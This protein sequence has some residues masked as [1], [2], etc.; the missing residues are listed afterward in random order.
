MTYL[1]L[2]RRLDDEHRREENKANTTKRPMERRIYP[3]GNDPKGRPYESLRW[4]RFKDMAPSEMFVIV[5]GTRVAEANL[6]GRARRR[7][8]ACRRGTS[9]PMATTPCAA[10]RRSAFCH[11][12]LLV[13]VAKALH[14]RGCGGASICPKYVLFFG[15]IKMPHRSICRALLR[16][17]A[18]TAS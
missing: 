2:I 12:S 7:A 4:S 18:S 3:E 14:Q 17:T 11:K 9:R 1:L 10:G 6:N 15:Q 16:S 13:F 5:A 8:S